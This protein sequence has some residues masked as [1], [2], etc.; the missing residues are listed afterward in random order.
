MRTIEKIVEKLRKYPQLTYS[1]DEDSITVDP[2]TEEGFSVYL[3]EKDSGFTVGFDGWHEEFEDEAEALDAFTFGLSNCCRI[4][5]TKRG[6]SECK[7]ALEA[8]EDGEWVKYSAV[9][10]IFIPFWRKKSIEYRQNNVI[11]AN[12]YDESS[13]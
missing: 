9:G 7:W 10:L 8:S 6:A 13:Q 5:V 4:R 12:R 3:T 2:P 1:R 11:L